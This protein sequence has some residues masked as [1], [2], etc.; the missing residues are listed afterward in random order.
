MLRD[1]VFFLRALWRQWKVLLTGGSVMA[2]LAMWTLVHG[3]H[4]PDGVGWLV[5][6]LTF[7]LAAFF[8]WRSEWIKAGRDFVEID[9][10]GVSDHCS[11]LTEPQSD[12][13][14]SR[15]AGKRIKVTGT[16]YDT[17]ESDSLK[18][19]AMRML[20]HLLLKDHAMAHCA[21]TSWNPGF[22]GVGEFQKG[23]CMTI[24]GRI[25]RASCS[26]P[27]VSLSLSGCELIEVKFPVRS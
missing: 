3:Q 13:F 19:F 23:I 8:S 5:V 26:P 6:G 18:P 9:F 1:F 11:E 4:L 21:V 14:M 22:N 20:I 16:L 24:S 2:L 27:V 7:M 10:K 25:Y 15:Y 17:A 12:R